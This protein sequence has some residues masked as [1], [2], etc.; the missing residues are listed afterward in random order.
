MGR[1]VYAADEAA[2]V[3]AL[4]GSAPAIRDRVVVED[5]D[6]PLARGATPSGTATDRRRRAR[7]GRGR[8]RRRTA[9]PTSSWPTPSTPAGRRRVDGRPS[10]I[11]PAYV[12]FRAVFVP[13]G[14]HTV[15]FRYRPAGF[16][17]GPG[18]QRRRARR[19]RLVCWS[20]RAGCPTSAAEHATLGWP[21]ALA[22]AGA[23]LVGSRADRRVSAVG[24]D[25]GG[26]ARAPLA[27]G[28]ELPR[29]TWGAGIEAMQAPGAAR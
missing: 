6:R 9:R 25:R 20:G 12:A 16:A 22:A 2:A 14:P 24:F 26:P 4:D 8:D 5:P 21:P 17:L 7:A 19:R 1:P 13:A 3:A 27:V 29:F 28:G 15:V 23:S 11:R 18:G 10:P